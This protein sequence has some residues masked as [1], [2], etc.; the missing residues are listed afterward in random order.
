VFSVLQR[1]R[2]HESNIYS[3]APMPFMQRL[4][5][6]GI[7]L[8]EGVVPGY[9]A[10]HGCIRLPAAFASQLWSTARIGMRVVVAPSDV[11][12]QSIAHPRLPVPRMTPVALNDMPVRLHTAALAAEGASERLLDPFLLA[13]TRKVKAAA[14]RDAAER[15]VKPA[16]AAATARSAE[17]S[18]AAEQLKAITVALERAGEE[19][20]D[21]RE[22]LVRNQTTEDDDDI[23]RAVGAAAAKVEALQAELEAAK[24]EERRL[25]NAAFAAARQSRETEFAV[26]EANEAQKLANIGME[27]ISIFVSLKEGRVFLRQGFNPIHDEPISVVEPNRPFGTH[28]YT[29]VAA[30]DGGAALRWVAVSVPNGGANGARSDGERG[31]R[32]AEQEDRVA[33]AASDAMS[34]LDRFEFPEVTLGLVRERLWPGA[35]L[36]VSDHGLGTETGAGTD[37]IVLTK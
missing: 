22:T 9:P 2:H 15:A 17:A 25:S 16:L 4:T 18:R 24:A 35:S 19:L 1:N 6:S 26:V 14:D 20:D 36:I 11:R 13:Q 3:G 29:A 33:Y 32:R 28:V 37:F 7:A 30:L 12:P 27:P 5:W 10:S 21:K 34:V 8:H 31:R 23:V